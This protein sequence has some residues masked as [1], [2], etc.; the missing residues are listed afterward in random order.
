MVRTAIGVVKAVRAFAPLN[1]TVTNVLRRIFGSPMRVPEAVI[2]HLP[3]VGGVSARLPNGRTMLLWSKGDDWIANQVFWRGALGYEPETSRIFWELAR[4][5]RATLDVGAHVGYYALL[6]AH[7]NPGA[8]V[9][10][11]EPLPPVHARLRRN[12]AL[13]DVP[14][15]RC[16][17]VAAG[18]WDGEADFFHS[19]EGI[20]SS[21][22]LSH[23]FMRE[24]EGLVRSSVPVRRLDGYLAESGLAHV[25][26]VKVDTES[27]EPQILRGMVDTLRRDRPTILCE[28]LPEWDVER[29]LHELLDPLG[30]EYFLLT[31]EGPRKRARIEADSEW[32]NHVFRVPEAG[33]V[34]TVF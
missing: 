24:L 6:A 3:R 21:S 17:A 9:F 19:P 16:V 26:L 20:P 12:V 30:Y 7:A 25:D 27:T 31:G 32:K 22:S 13:N 28:V 4:T 34:A 18:E 8:A 33:P 2:S 10:A 23:E 14:G 5:S 1:R 11:F 29:Q 15:L